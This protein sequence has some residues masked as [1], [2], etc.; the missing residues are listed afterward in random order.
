ME[1]LYHVAQTR[2]HAIFLSKTTVLTA[3]DGCRKFF[4]NLIACFAW[5]LE[6]LPVERNSMNQAKK[7]RA[8]KWVLIWHGI[9]TQRQWRDL[10]RRQFHAAMKAFN[11]YRVGCAWCE[12]HGKWVFEVSRALESAEKSHSVANWGR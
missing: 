2:Q 6:G 7:A 3:V 12:G 11:A 10:K 1:V 9:T 4:A 8:P 5:L